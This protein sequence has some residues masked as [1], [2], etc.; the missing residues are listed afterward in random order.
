MKSFL[1]AYNGKVI[2][3]VITHLSE[4]TYFSKIH[5]M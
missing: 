2:S 5:L 4:H 1:D 3:V